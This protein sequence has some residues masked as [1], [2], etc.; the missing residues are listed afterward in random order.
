MSSVTYAVAA[1]SIDRMPFLC[2]YKSCFNNS[3]IQGF[4]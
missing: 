4:I 3:F 2:S 1:L